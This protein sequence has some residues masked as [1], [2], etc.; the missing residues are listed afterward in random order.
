MATKIFPCKNCGKPVSPKAPT[1]Q[2]C[3]YSYLVERHRRI[4]WLATGILAAF[5]LIIVGIGIYGLLLS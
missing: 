2:H 3:G 1:C 4:G 5:V